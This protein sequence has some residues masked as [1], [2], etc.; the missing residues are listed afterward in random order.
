MQMFLVK[1]FMT[2]LHDDRSFTRFHDDRS[3][4]GTQAKSLWEKGCNKSL[5]FQDKSGQNFVT[6]CQCCTI[7]QVWKSK[8]PQLA[9]ELQAIADNP[10]YYQVLPTENVTVIVGG[11]EVEYIYKLEPY[12]HS[13]VHQRV[14]AQV[15]PAV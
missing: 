8:H 6:N 14:N 3:F 5:T 9:K 10:T 7:Y 15:L 1:E 4:G 13:L 11:Q 2:D 12:V